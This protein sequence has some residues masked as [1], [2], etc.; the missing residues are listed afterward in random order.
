MTTAAHPVFRP[1]ALALITGG[2][3]GIGLALAHLCRSKGMRVALVDTNTQFLEKAQTSLSSAGA[4]SQDAVAT[5][6]ADV[7]KIDE[8]NRIRDEVKA[9][10]GGEGTVDFLVLNAGIGL[11]G[12]WGDNEYFQKIMST[13]LFGVINGL[14]TFIPAMQ[15]AQSKPGSKPSAVVITG[16]KQ[17]I[18]N[19]PGNA[20]YN[21]SKSA[22]KTLAEHLN[23]DLRDVEGMSVHLLVPGWTFTGLSGGHPGSEKQKPDGAWTPAQVVDYLYAKMSPDTASGAENGQTGQFY[24]ICP[25]NDVDEATDRKR[26]LWAAGDVAERRPPLNRWRGGVWTEKVK[27]WMSKV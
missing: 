10:F 6:A 17:G 26:I 18:T 27:T 24:V 4:G 19:P 5:I 14:S 22:I 2:A 15:S 21:A 13:N 20:A 23:F 9:K 12:E 3:S 1:N 7:S 25:D 16:S 11:K 8:W